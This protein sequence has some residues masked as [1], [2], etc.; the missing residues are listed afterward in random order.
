MSDST[1][2]ITIERKHSHVEICLHDD[3]AFNCKT[4][5]FERFEF[6]HNALP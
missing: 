5:G 3:I 1:G 2:N 6:E 4:T